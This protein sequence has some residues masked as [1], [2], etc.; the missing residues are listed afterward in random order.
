MLDGTD[1]RYL[2]S[3]WNCP[4]AIA[5][6]SAGG[7]SARLWSWPARSQAAGSTRWSNCPTRAA[8]RTLGRHAL[9]D[10]M[11]YAS[12]EPCPMCLA[13]AY[14]AAIPRIV[15]AAPTADCMNSCAC[16]PGS[17]R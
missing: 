17:D 13:A 16:Q 15:F 12:A 6:T 3:R 5:T 11:L 2:R 10:G 7:R 4:G 8:G 1:R 14:W 9:D